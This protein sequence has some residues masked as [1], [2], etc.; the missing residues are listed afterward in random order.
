MRPLVI[1]LALLPIL[2]VLAPLS[3]SADDGCVPVRAHDRTDRTRVEGYAWNAPGRN[4]CRPG[5]ND[6]GRNSEG[7][8]RYGRTGRD[9][10]G[11]PLMPLGEEY[12]AR[13]S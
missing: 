6:V 12:P 13:T 10:D 8:S 5:P 1:A 11:V 9:V 4:G 7:G 3:A 2:S